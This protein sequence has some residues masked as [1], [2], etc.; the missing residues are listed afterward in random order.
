MNRDRLL[1][2]FAAV[3]MTAL[4]ISAANAALTLDTTN[5][6]NGSIPGGATNDLLSSALFGNVGTTTGTYGAQVFHDGTTQLRFDFLGFE[7]GFVNTFNTGGQSFDTESVDVGSNNVEIAA[8]LAA[9]LD[10][11]T[12]SGINGLI[13][14]SFLVNSGAA[15][16]A[17]GANPN[18]FGGGA[19][20]NFFVSHFSATSLILWLDDAGAGPDDNHDD[21][22]IRI[23]EVPNSE[24][25]EPTTLGLLG[26]GLLG[27]G[28]AGRR[29]RRC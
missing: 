29:R 5:A 23:S 25:P 17:N 16:V 28:L 12:T 20:V 9:P 14:F 8:S 13:D 7:A 6:T 1:S 10:F 22:V 3:V 19:G 15:S 2:G 18:D 11:F 21:M 26:I 24:V 27:L 4:G